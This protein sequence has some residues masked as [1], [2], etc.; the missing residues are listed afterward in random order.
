MI[1]RINHWFYAERQLTPGATVEK[2]RQDLWTFGF[3]NIWLT[4]TKKDAPYVAS[5]LWGADKFEIEFEPRKFLIIRAAK[6]NDW[7]KTA[8]TRALGM[9]PHF[10]YQDKANINIHEWRMADRD[11]RWQSMQGLPAFKS[12]KRL[13]AV[14]EA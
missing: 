6:E 9:A 7:L 3:Y 14:A 10:Q 12:L 2:M 5:G 13:Y 8:F 11:G 1:D 4:L